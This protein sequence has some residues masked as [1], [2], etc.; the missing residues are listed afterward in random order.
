MILALGGCSTYHQ[1]TKTQNNAIRSG[2]F[3]TAA[4][5][6]LKRAEKKQGDE[7]QL[8]T[9]LELG[10]AMRH[11][12]LLHADGATLITSTLNPKAYEALL[13]KEEGDPYGVPFDATGMHYLTSSVN[14][15]EDAYRTAEYWDSQPDTSV[16]DELSSLL[17]EQAGRPYKSTVSERVMADTYQ[18]LN[19]LQLGRPEDARIAFNRMHAQQKAAVDRYAKDIE[20]AQLLAAE[21]DK[22]GAGGYNGGRALSDDRVQSELGSGY[23]FLDS[24]AAYGDFTNPFSLWLEGIFL[25]QY[26][27]SQQD[28]DDAV[29]NLEMV[30]AVADNREAFL[31]L[32]ELANQSAAEGISPEGMTYVVFETGF[33]PKLDQFKIHVPIFIVNSGHLPYT[34]VGIPTIQKQDDAVTT[35]QIHADGAVHMPA[36][37]C[38]MDRVV[39]EDFNRRR[40]LLITRAIISAGAKAT[41]SYI[42]NKTAE[43]QGGWMAGLA[44]K[45]VTSVYQASTSNA[46]MRSWQFLP[47]RFYTVAFKTP[48]DG[49][50]RIESPYAEHAPVELKLSPAR[51]N[52]VY[53][54]SVGA[55]TPLL[56]AQF[57]LDPSIESAQPVVPQL[58]PHTPDPL[59]EEQP[60]SPT[61]DI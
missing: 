25:L 60:L 2:D 12:G 30:A 1:Q 61:H 31:P 15:F 52:L 45:V 14:I 8:V 34:A 54:R 49:M 3:A 46:D 38:D 4:A 56:N 35:L 33:A 53:L 40:T 48:E 39:V 23:A 5:E 19:Y 17:G 37:V 59:Q 50:V 9:L 42:A 47:K 24:M 55:N 32:L 18:A 44:S 28:L 22:G 13:A 51:S 6:A 21:S 11:L 7:D 36:V 16:G 27:E 43:E 57:P 58:I 10:S 29:R 26:A 20:K 41:I